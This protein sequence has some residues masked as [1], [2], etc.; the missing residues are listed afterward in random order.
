MWVDEGMVWVRFEF[1]VGMDVVLVT[2]KIFFLSCEPE[3]NQH[4]FF[5]ARTKK[6]CWMRFLTV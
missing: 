6:N 1:D 5:L 4:F 3:A 2:N